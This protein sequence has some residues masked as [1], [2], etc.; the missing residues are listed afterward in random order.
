VFALAGLLGADSQVDLPLVMLA[1]LVEHG[2]HHDHAIWSAP[3]AQTTFLP[4]LLLVTER[5]AFW[6]RMPRFGAS[7]RE[8]SR[9]WAGIGSQV[10]RRPVATAVIVLVLLGAACAGLASL[11][12]DNNPIAN[13]KTPRG[14][15]A[16]P[17]PSSIGVELWISPAGRPETRRWAIG[18]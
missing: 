18:Q 7:G 1:G 2:Q 6:P 11:S 16:L 9:I 13:G 4:A 14:P 10:A 5:G 8:E 15:R 3:L 12:I 17:A